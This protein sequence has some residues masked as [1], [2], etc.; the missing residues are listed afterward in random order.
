M[1]NYLF[2]FSSPHL[3]FYEDFSSY[4]KELAAIPDKQ[5]QIIYLNS[6]QTLDSFIFPS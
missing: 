3:N 6:T 1:R 4:Q 5:H 2:R